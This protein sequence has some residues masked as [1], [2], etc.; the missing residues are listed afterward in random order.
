MPELAGQSRNDYLALISRLENTDTDTAR[1]VRPVQVWHG[2]DWPSLVT[3]MNEM[4]ILAP[5]PRGFR[6]MKI[7]SWLAE[8]FSNFVQVARP[9]VQ[10]GI[11]ADIRLFSQRYPY[12]MKMNTCSSGIHSW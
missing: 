10:G 7:R 1:G 6:F 5:H 11:H 9:C 2:V 8:L 12:T 3:A 4:K